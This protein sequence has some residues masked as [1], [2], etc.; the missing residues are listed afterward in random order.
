[1]LT[2]QGIAKIVTRFDGIPRNFRE[3]IEFIEKYAVPICF[4]R[5]QKVNS[6]SVPGCEMSCFIQRHMQASEAHT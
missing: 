6:I 2:A 1:M 5:P 3:W 4:S